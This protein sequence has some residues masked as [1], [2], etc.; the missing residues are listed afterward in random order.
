MYTDPL[1]AKKRKDQDGTE[2]FILSGMHGDETN[3]KMLKLLF[4]I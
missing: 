1:K 4:L 2:Y 3:L